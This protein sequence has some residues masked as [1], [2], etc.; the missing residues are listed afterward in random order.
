MTGQ[1]RYRGGLFSGLL[2]V[3]ALCLLSPVLVGADLLNDPVSRADEALG[4]VQEQGIASVSLQQFIEEIRMVADQG[5]LLVANNLTD[6]AEALAILIVQLHDRINRYEESIRLLDTNQSFLQQDLEEAKLLFVQEDY[7]EADLALD[8]VLAR[9]QDAYHAAYVE[10][11]ATLLLLEDGLE[12]RDYPT[13][14][15]SIQE[16]RLAEQYARGDAVGMA[17]TRAALQTVLGVLPDLDQLAELMPRFS[18]GEGGVQT[19]ADYETDARQLV[20]QGDIEGLSALVEDAAIWES[21]IEEADQRLRDLGAT[22]QRVQDTAVRAHLEALLAAA[23]QAIGQGDP[24]LA[25]IRA[26]TVQE[27]YEQYQSHQLW[28]SGFTEPGSLPLLAKLLRIIIWA[29]CGLLVLFIFF[30]LPLER[31]YYQYRMQRLHERKEQATLFL[32]RM[33]THYFQDRNMS[34]PQ[35]EAA[36]ERYEKRLCRIMEALAWIRHNM[37]RNQRGTHHDH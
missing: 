29:V 17:S 7:H 19:I 16:G 3:A 36:R 31:R 6:E 8:T 25:M 30:R 34:R 15:V 2:L 1:Y 9:L 21:D 26:D 24:A 22:I 37:Q 13:T 12:Q 33:Q 28:S 32:K 20:A 10:D 4:T 11:Q 35:F 27:A 18:P 14:W 23:Q 5:D